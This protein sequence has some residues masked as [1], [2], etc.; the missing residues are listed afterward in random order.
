MINNRLKQNF[1]TFYETAN[2]S[3]KIFL[4][5]VESS[6]RVLKM[7]TT[8][9]NAFVQTFAKS[10]TALLIKIVVCGKSSQICCSALLALEWSLA[11]GEVCEMPEALHPTH[12]SQ[13][14]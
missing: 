10:L 14:G 4:H 3:V 13:V 6:H 8:G 12:G 7:S 5:K 9:R 1:F 11:L 2:S